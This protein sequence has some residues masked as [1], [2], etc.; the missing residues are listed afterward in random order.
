M[1]IKVESAELPEAEVM[2][3]GDVTSEEVISLLQFLKKKSS[4]K[5][6]FCKEEEQYIMDTDEIVFLEVSDGKVYANTGHDVYEAKMKLYELKEMLRDQAFAQI[7]KSVIVNINYVKS[8]QAEFSGNYRIK[9][10]N[11]KES[12][13]IS[14]KYFKEFK[15]RI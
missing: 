5:L 3:R 11:R 8:I 1:K 12:L 6:I 7:N 4:G 9:L 10:K 14:R 2:I 15:D 13:T